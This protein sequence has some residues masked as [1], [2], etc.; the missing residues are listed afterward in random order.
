MGGSK[1][2][3]MVIASLVLINIFFL[4][5]IVFDRAD[6]ARREKRVIENVCA[7]MVSN[8]I[9]LSPDDISVNMRLRAMKTVRSQ[10]AEQTIAQAVLGPVFITDRGGNIYQY[11]NQ[12]S[13]SAVFDSAGGFTISVN[14]GV[15]SG[16][17]G[18]EAEVNKLLR[19]M[20]LETMA[21]STKG[22]A[23]SEIVTAVCAYKKA[24]IFNCT[25]RFTFIGGSLREIAGRYAP[26]I[27]PEEN[28]AAIS[29]VSTALL[30]F[31][32]FVKSGETVCGRKDSEIGRAHV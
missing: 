7:V 26:G 1:I 13:G 25:V 31:L 16:D 23:G 19:A 27:A 15:V 29:P 12:N 22:G 14:A 5:V 11:E 32:A 30:Q 17:G 8:G 9:Q 6:D 18:A 3:S 4:A 2:K 10:Q 24:D 20:K 28:G 21:L